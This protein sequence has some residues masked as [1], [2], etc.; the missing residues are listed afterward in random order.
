MNRNAKPDYFRE[1]RLWH[2]FDIKLTAMF[3]L[4]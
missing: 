3:N 4:G 2:A 1:L